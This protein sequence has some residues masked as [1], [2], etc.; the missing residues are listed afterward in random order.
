M[1]AIPVNCA[2]CGQVMLASAD[3]HMLAAFVCLTC[4]KVEHEPQGEA[5]RLFTPAPNQLDGQLNF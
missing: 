3:S 2:R 1:T 5:V 4:V